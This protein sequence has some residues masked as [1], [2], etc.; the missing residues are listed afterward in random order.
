[1]PARVSLG[2][3]VALAAAC[4]DD[5]VP[6][7]PVP[8][9]EPL[10]KGEICEADNSAALALHF[11]PPRIVLAPGAKRP[12][13]LSVDPDLCT[14]HKVTFT[15]KSAGVSVPAEGT[16]DLRHPAV[17]FE[18]EGKAIGVT[19]VT[20]RVD[21]PDANDPSKVETVEIE[22]AV[23][24][25]DAAVPTCQPGEGLGQGTLSGQSPVVF[26]QGPLAKASVGSPAGAFSRTDEMALPSVG[27]SVTCQ[28][29]LSA[30]AGYLA[31]GPAVTYEG[32]A[33]ITSSSVLRRELDFTVPVNPAAMPTK[34]RMRHLEVLYQGPRAKAPRQVAVS[35][36][37]IESDGANG[38]VLKF[39]APWLGTYQ[40]VVRKDAGEGTH[41]RKLTHRAVLGFSMGGG[42]SASFGLRHH[43]KFDAVAPL[44]GLSDYNWLTWYIETYLTGG[45]CPA[46]DPNCTKYEP[47]RY[48]IAEPFAHTMDF[49]HFWY[50]E[51][52]GNGGTFA[53]GS[54]VQIFGD[55]ALAF[56]NLASQNQ[57]PTLSHMVAGPKKTDPWIKGDLSG[58][59]GVPE[60]LDCSFAVSPVSDAKDVE[61][62]R[63][64]EQACSKFRCDPQNQWKAAT[65]YFDDEYNPA[66]D[67]PVVTFCD[68]GQKGKSPYKN[69]WM[70]IPGDHTEPVNFAVA[71]D[72]NNNGV[73]DENEPVIRSGHEPYD[74]CGTDGVCDKDEPGF[75][76]VKNPDPNQD[77]YDYFLNPDGKEGDHHYEMGERFR[78]DG[79][80]G[81]PNTK[82][83]HVA[84]DPG[85]GD[86]VY[87]EALGFQNVRK[88]DA[89]S[90][91]KN[92][93]DSVPGGPLTDEALKRLDVTTDGGVRDL[94]NFAS[95]ANHLAGSIASR[96]GQDGRQLKSVAFYN[97]YENLPG[98][99]PARPQDFAPGNILWSDIVDVPNLRYGTV[100]ATP[101][102]ILQGDGMHVGT[103]A[104]LL[105]RLLFGFYYVAQRWPDADHTR[106]EVALDNPVTQGSGPFEASC[107]V[108]GRCEHFFTG[109]KSKRTGPI[110]ISL[111]PGYGNADNAARDVRYPVVYV[112][113]GYGQDPRDLE[114]V[115]LITGNFMN[116]GQRS[117]ANR[118][119]K[120]IVVYVDGR[121]RS[122]DGRP[123]CIQGSF[124]VD[125]SRPGGPQFDTWFDEVV[126]FVDQSFRTMKPSEID[127]PN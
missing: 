27:A 7:G 89:H 91:V 8:T 104:Q 78:D 111:P 126:D 38:Y 25:R 64:I 56:G 1:M 87:S 98:Q 37:R 72:L 61:L 84:G 34:S 32:T 50:E 97:G 119:P 110:A 123:E 33:P 42:G 81:V 107:I 82:D 12:V 39:S 6:S 63:K 60:G 103:A 35:N 20:A 101:Q 73:R 2:F 80:D 46:S 117:S 13:K 44:G 45:F 71:V 16:V 31:L 77:D 125:S 65:G 15:A 124:Y 108:Q 43:D 115:A 49:N 122:Q 109:P 67:K 40:A 48:P 36:P 54:Y 5:A 74:D 14:P 9:A 53:R 99:D 10:P 24:V 105:N 23:D 120:F 85:E 41:K 22:L 19:S 29:D 30:A 106:S 62:Q 92:W 100:D 113:H 3:L 90:I 55:L 88:F 75:D 21:R 66:G 102:Q 57:D 121:C 116:D 76:A 52:N 112:L 4:G 11:D 93:T 58:I 70:P 59:P 26:G 79:F 94:F 69:T 51:G 83:R 96:K 114:A 18:V 127:V 68:G 17:D 28:G 86:G 118:L 47:N 95:A